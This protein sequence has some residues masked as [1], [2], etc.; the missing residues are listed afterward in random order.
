MIFKIENIKLMGIVA[1]PYEI[2]EK[3]GI[4]YKATLYKD[5]EFIEV[6]TSEDVWKDVGDKEELECDVY[7]ELKTTEYNGKK[8]TSLFLREVKYS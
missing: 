1:K 8:N 4:S 5:K 3:K 2:N 7:V 6:K